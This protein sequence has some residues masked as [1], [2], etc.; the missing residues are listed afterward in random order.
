MRQRSRRFL[1]RVLVAVVL[2]VAPLPCCDA[3][4]AIN[5]SSIPDTVICEPMEELLATVRALVAPG[6]G[7]LA[8][9]ESNGTMGKRVSCARG[10]HFAH[11]AHLQRA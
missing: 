9:D 1:S 7:I 8:A 3:K 10:L 11:N 4:P 5:T 2:F 6:K